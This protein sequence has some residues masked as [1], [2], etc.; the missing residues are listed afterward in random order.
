MPAC[1]TGEEI[2]AAPD[3][4]LG[5]SR[6]FLIQ[7]ACPA[8]SC[9]VASGS[10][11]RRPGCV[12]GGGAPGHGSSRI[13][14]SSLRLMDTWMAPTGSPLWDLSKDQADEIPYRGMER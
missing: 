6:C 7:G 1:L 11:A 10:S 9:A 4:A 13:P 2:A 14:A 12:S 5:S 3:T 8:R